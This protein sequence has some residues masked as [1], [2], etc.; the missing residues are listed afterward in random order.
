[1]TKYVE[2][3]FSLRETAAEQNLQAISRAL[4][5][6]ENK[7][8]TVKELPG[9]NHLLQTAETGD[10]SEYVK[11]EETMSPTALQI[12]GDWIQEQTE[13]IRTPRV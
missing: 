3:G 13:S 4:K 1:M 6:G 7:N 9:L 10:I 11:I 2:K 12:I 5:A 8:Y